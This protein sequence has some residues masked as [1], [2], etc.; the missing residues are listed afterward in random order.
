LI[1]AVNGEIDEIVGTELLEPLETAVKTETVLSAS[2][3]VANPGRPTVLVD[4]NSPVAM[5][6]G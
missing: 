6:T 5:A 1:K 2:F 3:A 4:V